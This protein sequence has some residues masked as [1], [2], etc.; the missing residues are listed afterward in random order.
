MSLDIPFLWV[1]QGPKQLNKWWL[2]PEAYSPISYGLEVPQT[3]LR[4][5]TGTFSV[6][7]ALPNPA[8][9]S[10]S[11]SISGEPR[12]LTINRLVGWDS[13][14]STVAAF[15]Y[16]SPNAN[17]GWLVEV[18]LSGPGDDI[19]LLSSYLDFNARESWGYPE[20]RQGFL[21]ADPLDDQGLVYTITRGDGIYS[22]LRDP[23]NVQFTP[24]ARAAVS[25]YYDFPRPRGAI[26]CAGR[27]L[28]ECTY[29]EYA[30]MVSP[31]STNDATLQLYLRQSDL[32]YTPTAKPELFSLLDPSTWRVFAVWDL[33][34]TRWPLR[35]NGDSN[36]SEWWVY[37]CSQLGNLFTQTPEFR[38]ASINATT[39]Q[40][41]LRANY[42]PDPTILLSYPDLV[43]AESARLST[44]ADSS[45]IPPHGPYFTNGL[46]PV[47]AFVAPD[48]FL[49]DSI[50]QYDVN[51]WDLH[52]SWPIYQ[53]GYNYVSGGPTVT[54]KT[55]GEY[56]SYPFIGDWDDTDVPTAS[57]D[58]NHVNNPCRVP[59]GIIGQDDCHYTVV[60]EP[61]FLAT[62]YNMNLTGGYVVTDEGE[63]NV[64]YA[65]LIKDEY[66]N[67]IL[68]S[69]G[70][71]IGYGDDFILYRTYVAPSDG[72]SNVGNVIPCAPL[73]HY[74]NGGYNYGCHRSTIIDFQGPSAPVP[75][76]QEVALNM[77]LGAPTTRP[78]YKTYLICTQDSTEK[79]KVDITDYYSWPDDGT[80]SSNDLYK[81]DDYPLLA[82]VWQ[83][84]LV[85][86]VLF[87]LRQSVWAGD[88]ENTLEHSSDLKKR[89]PYIEVRDRL[90]GA[91]LKKANLHPPD[92]LSDRTLIGDYTHVPRM[93]VGFDKVEGVIQPWATIWTQWQLAAGGTAADTRH[94]ITEVSWID[95]D[96][97]RADS[98]RI[99]AKPAGAPSALEASILA[100]NKNTAVWID[101]AQN[102]ARQSQP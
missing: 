53:R 36:A 34:T 49:Y 79:Y 74:T 77:G 99:G 23:Y 42:T 71:F 87:V 27:F 63:S 20:R 3:P 22:V 12:G 18:L 19:N 88:E 16:P 38:L 5:S 51:G 92:D 72:A 10:E 9:G 101:D 40:L 13:H 8:Y 43:S 33:L 25:E 100:L 48:G 26:G 64:W 97:V 69:S 85:G 7:Q 98:L 62:E 82:S 44:F 45:R 59:S 73:L 90:T 96:I 58:Y 54:S 93:V 60:H 65:Y 56:F 28:I 41:T 6:L 89:E 46:G 78:C 91:L 31:D 52:K 84:A 29:T 55:G 4:F 95:S 102:A 68:D 50:S 15:Y 76:W 32:T 61:H 24:W 80:Q 83:I 21:F 66:L 14:L 39:G 70:W 30:T 11:S 47:F 35:S 2:M 67:P 1:R 37:I 75:D 17:Y 57:D 94:A 81:A 86:D